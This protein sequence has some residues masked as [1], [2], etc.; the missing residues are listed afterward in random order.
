MAPSISAGMVLGPST[1]RFNARMQHLIEPKWRSLSDG[2]FTHAP[3]AS[4]HLCCYD[5]CARGGG[6]AAPGL[7]HARYMDVFGKYVGHTG[8]A[9]MDI[10]TQCVAFVCGCVGAC[11]SVWAWVCIA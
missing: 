9:H 8:D 3:Q 4:M 11:V 10:S 7:S 6:A 5:A 2:D 1:F